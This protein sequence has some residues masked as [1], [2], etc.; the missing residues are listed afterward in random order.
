MPDPQQ[1]IQP[2]KRRHARLAILA[3]G[4]LAVVAATVLAHR[5]LGRAPGDSTALPGHDAPS[6]ITLVAAGEPGAPL[7]VTGQ[8]F[9][10]DGETPA[11][12]IVL[13][14]YQTDL[15]GR[16]N[17]LPMQAPRLR[18]WMK[19]DAEGQYEYR[20][21]RPASYPAS[22]IAQHIHTQL[23]GDGVPAQWGKDLNFADDPFVS[24]P[25]KTRS[26]GAGRFG[27]VCEA[28][29][30]EAGVTHCVHN[31]RLKAT[32]DEFGVGTRHGFR[33]DPQ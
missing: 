31:L 23:W 19:T 26:T 17:R 9:L 21:V 12:G 8:V 29:V 7:R 30:D 32:G 28:R 18:G 33:K 15:T 27:W 3:V 5:V 1:P 10:P 14:V 22:S 24:A 20:T 25:D 13:Y 2:A 16:Y 11:A 4:S 6:T